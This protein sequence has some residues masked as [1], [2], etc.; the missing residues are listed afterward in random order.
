VNISIPNQLVYV[1]PV[2]LDALVALRQLAPAACL[3]T[4]YQVEHARFALII[5]QPA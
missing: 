5:V 1:Q 3:S 2:A 4:I